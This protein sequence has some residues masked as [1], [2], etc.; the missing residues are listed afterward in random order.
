[1]RGAIALVWRINL[2]KLL[3]IYNEKFALWTQIYGCSGIFGSF[4]VAMWE[5]PAY[6]GLP[7]ISIFMIVSG[8]AFCGFNKFIE[9]MGFKEYYNKEVEYLQKKISDGTLPPDRLDMFRRCFKR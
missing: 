6:V 5:I 4:F 2:K 3:K 1:M 7:V 9:D 8:F